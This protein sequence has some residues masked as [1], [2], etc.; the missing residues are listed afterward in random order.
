MQK[1]IFVACSILTL[2]AIVGFS[3]IGC[4]SSTSVTTTT[5]GTVG[6]AQ[7]DTAKS[8]VLMAGGA[9]SIGVSAN[10]VG[11]SAG[12]S[13][14]ASAIR[15]TWLR[16]FAG[17]PPPAFFT[18]DLTTSTDGYFAPSSTVLGGKMQPYIR[19]HTIGG[20]IVNGDYLTTTEGGVKKIADLSPCTVEAIFAG[21][22]TVP[23]VGIVTGTQN[24][25]TNW[26]ANPTT[27]Y[28]S[29]KY[30]G[31]Y[32][33]W[34]YIYP[35]IEAKINASSHPLP[36]A[37]MHLTTP[38]AGNSDKIKSMDNKMVF[39]GIV[40]GEIMVNVPCEPDGRASLGT[41]S[42]TGKLLTPGSTMDVTTSLTFTTLGQPP[43]LVTVVATNE[44]SPFYT[45]IV[46]VTSPT[47]GVGTG[48]IWDYSTSP[49]TLIGTLTSSPTGGSITVG[50]T[51]ETFT[52]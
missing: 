43:S 45:T 37:L 50:A 46:Y 29:I 24:F 27:A 36:S 31:D 28:T 47:T 2:I 34:A 19:L 23:P 13:P 38:L 40:T 6:A 9:A 22:P 49:G 39:S 17:N 18:Y 7:L 20:S 32:L 25:I 3:A 1:K 12:S 33:C 44:T 15:S 41:T 4:G 51:T 21:S 42:G 5:N 16:S 10:T 48:E 8:G 26:L 30:M 35:T 14:A 52:F 11:G